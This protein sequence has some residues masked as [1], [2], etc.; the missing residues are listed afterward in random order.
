MQHYD[1]WLV[2]GLIC[3]EH[4]LMSYSQYEPTS[5]PNH[6]LEHVDKGLLTIILDPQDVEVEIRPADH[7]PVDKTNMTQEI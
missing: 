4:S 5:E 6:C 3:P 1:F 2:R 7:Y